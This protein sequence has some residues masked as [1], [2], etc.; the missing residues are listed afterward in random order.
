MVVLIVGIMAA[1]AIPMMRGR[2][3]EAKWTEG[4]ST[5]GTIAS[6]IRVYAGEK[7]ESGGYGDNQPPMIVLGFIP[8]D[9]E[10]SYFTST[11]FSWT[12]AYSAS[13]NP[14]LTF[15]ITATAPAGISSPTSRTLNHLGEWT[16]SP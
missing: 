2:I 14:P 4:R 5:M 11:N 9:L 16:E 3:D 10:G 8:S 15:T 1:V 7:R 13:G 6:A 12:T